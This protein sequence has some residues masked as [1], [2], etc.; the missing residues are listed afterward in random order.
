MSPDDRTLREL[1]WMADAAWEPWAIVYSYMTSFSRETKT[2]NEC[3]PM[4]MMKKG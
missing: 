4:R 1:V 2:P 3:H